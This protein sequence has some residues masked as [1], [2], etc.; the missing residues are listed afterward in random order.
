[1]K[2]PQTDKKQEGNSGIWIQGD[3]DGGKSENVK[4]GPKKCQQSGEIFSTEIM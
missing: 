1:M 2:C 3:G 4:E